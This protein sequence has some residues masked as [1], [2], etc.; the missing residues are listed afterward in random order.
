MISFS[1]C[2]FKVDGYNQ[3]KYY[4]MCHVSIVKTSTI[5]LIVILFVGNLYFLSVQL[6]CFTSCLDPLWLLNLN[7]HVYIFFSSGEYLMNMPWNSASLPF[8]FLFF[9]NSNY[10]CIKCSWP[11]FL[12][13]NLSFIFNN[14]LSHWVDFWQIFSGSIF[15]F[16][17]LI[18][19][20]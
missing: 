14:S 18:F 3:L 20:L 2:L 4:I 16:P 10:I 6:G 13:L 17:I 15:H 12:A 1:G 7:L 11:N 19:S 9:Q 8:P 5:S